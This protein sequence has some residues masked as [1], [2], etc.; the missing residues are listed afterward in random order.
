MPQPDQD[1][2]QADGRIDQCNPSFFLKKIAGGRQDVVNGCQ[3]FVSCNGPS[4]IGIDAAASHLSVGGVAYDH[5]RRGAGH[6]RI[7]DIPQNDAHP[8]VQTVQQNIAHGLGGQIFLDFEAYGM[9]HRTCEEEDKG[10]N[11]APGPEIDHPIPRPDGHELGQEDRIDGETVPISG[12]DDL[13]PAV[14]KW[15]DGLAGQELGMADG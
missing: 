2:C 4:Q 5:V 3:E 6:G 14:Q 13:E 9:A 8:L 11:A 15:V 7:S 12:L 10:D 1:I